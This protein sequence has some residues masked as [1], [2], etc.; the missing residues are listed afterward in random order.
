MNSLK[1][2][3]KTTFRLVYSFFISDN[4]KSFDDHISYRIHLLCLEKC[5]Q[6]YNLFDECIFIIQATD[7]NNP[8]INELKHILSEYTI[9]IKKVSYIIEENDPYEREGGIFEKYIIN[10]FNDYD[11][12]TL[13]FHNKGLNKAYG[14]T[15]DTW[16]S[17]WIIGEYYYLMLHI[18]DWFGDFLHLNN[19]LIYGWPHMHDNFHK[20]WLIGGN[21]FWMKCKDIQKYIEDNNL[22]TNYITSKCVSEFYFP[23][24]FNDEVVEYPNS[25][26]IKN[27]F[28][29]ANYYEPAFNDK[30]NEFLKNTTPYNDYVLFD[31][32]YNFIINQYY[33]YLTKNK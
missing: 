24:I 11:G 17:R 28:E 8:L 23:E 2:I 4:I 31:K 1:L 5:L 22:Q 7:V 14:D 16:C 12:L 32:F 29:H 18:K 15:L 9:N 3:D 25:N 30:F 26:V 27:Y 33:V 13:F 10:K 21:C 6:H 20:Q 19:K